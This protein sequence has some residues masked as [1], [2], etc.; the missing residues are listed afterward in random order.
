[1]SGGNFPDDPIAPELSG[2]AERDAED[3]DATLADQRK[4]RDFREENWF[5][6][7]RIGFLLGGAVAALV[8]IA[9]YLLHLLLPE[10][11]RWLSEP[12]VSRLEKAALTIIVGIVCSLATTYFFGRK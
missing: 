2:A 11:L 9:V 7:V 3:L 1:M 8:F 6:R 5:Y 12:D 4:R 10:C